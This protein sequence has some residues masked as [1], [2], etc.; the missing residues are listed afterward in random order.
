VTADEVTVPERAPSEGSLTVK[1]RSVRLAVR[2]PGS[3]D[4]AAHAYD[5]KIKKLGMIAEDVD[6]SSGGRKKSDVLLSLMLQ[7]QTVSTRYDFTPGG[8]VTQA[9]PGHHGPPPLVDSKAV[10]KR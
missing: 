6:A 9:I 3:A 10:K 7:Y 8:G 1:R 5:V 2:L 4:Q